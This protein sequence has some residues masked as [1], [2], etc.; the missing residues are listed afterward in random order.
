MVAIVYQTSE[1]SILNFLQPGHL[2]DYIFIPNSSKRLAL[3]ADSANNADG[4]ISS[5]NWDQL[6]DLRRKLITELKDQSATLVE[7]ESKQ[8]QSI[9]AAIKKTRASLDILTD[10][11][12]QNRDEI[13]KSNGELL[14][15]S[16]NISQAKNFLSI[17]QSR[18]PPE[19]ED[20]LIKDSLSYTSTIDEKRYNSEREKNE[21]MSKSKEITMKLEGIRA[22]K[23]VS[24]Q[25][26]SLSKQTGVL[27]DSIAVL[28]QKRNSTQ[29]E[30]T[31]S[32]AELDRLFDT[33][34]SL[35]AER[36]LLLSEY[37][38]KLKQLDEVN[39]RLD[40][41][42]EM[43]KKQREQYGYALPNDVLFKVKENARKK[44]EEGSKLS[45]EE[46]KLLYEDGTD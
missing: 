26:G 40:S 25:L 45:F 32:N 23:T 41:M 21:L 5:L 7:I 34:R 33:K 24:D 2:T 43:R 28:M 35:T 30:I 14:K 22:A 6:V 16:E 17:M 15:L 8:L 10:K 46:L 44:L 37:G 11:A 27:S 13:E 42:S 19:S 12:K 3:D 20:Q 36:D 38:E 39:S 1:I 9:Q 31:R 29:D 4:T 18:L